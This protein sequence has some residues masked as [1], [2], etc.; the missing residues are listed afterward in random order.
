MKK[1]TLPIWVLVFVFILA[2]CTTSV[3]ESLKPSGIINGI[4]YN[5]LSKVVDEDVNKAKLL[6]DIIIDTASLDEIK[7]R[8]FL[9]IVWVKLLNED[10]F[11]H[12]YVPEVVGVYVYTSK[13]KANSGMGQ[14]IGMISKNRDDKK[15]PK[16]KVSEIQ[17][18]SLKGVKENKW[19][20]SYEQRQEIWIK[21]IRAED[22]AQVEADKKYPRDKPGATMDYFEKSI[23]FKSQLIKQ[24]EKEIAK[25][26]GVDI[27]IIDS[28]GYEGLEYGWAFPR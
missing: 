20:L 2:S 18:K 24:N 7:L 16:F 4:K 15:G 23:D 28:I 26:Y 14:W 5:V 12:H 25:E 9:A 22:K 6:V 13:E 1:L 19:G 8:G 21:V 10:N 27:V 17:M 11:E 3:R